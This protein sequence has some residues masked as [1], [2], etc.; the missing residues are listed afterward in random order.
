MRFR[1]AATTMGALA[2]T[3]AMAVGLVPSGATASPEPLTYVNLG[4]SYSAGSGLLPPAPE[5]S[6][7]CMQSAHNY[8]KI[9]ARANGFD[10]TD[11]SCGGATT[12]DFF[13]SQLSGV[14]PQL[15][16]LDDDVDLVTF[17]IGGNDDDL[18]AG[19]VMNCVIEGVGG[20]MRGSPCEDKYA[21]STSKTIRES[22]Y[23][24]LVKA[25]KAVREKAP[26]ARVAAL[27]Y[28]W[29]APDRDAPCNGMPVSPGDGKFTH[30]V[31]AQLNDAIA[32]AAKKTGVALVDVATPSTGHDACKPVG[33]RWVEPVLTTAQFVP[34]HP[35]MLGERRMAEVTAQ[36]L[37]LE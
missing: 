32:R 12:A 30:A 37:D 19:T 22:T 24:N 4:D 34:V 27:N 17:S 3:A 7:G 10:L 29:I 21:G 35:N 5:A 28:P 25:M 23:P 18:F 2:A 14:K 15:D 11:V 9:V 31:Q 6:I 8:A 16:A 33:V 36:T 26:N 20:G 13:R 1:R